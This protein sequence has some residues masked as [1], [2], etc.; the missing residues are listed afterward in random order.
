MLNFVF[1][2]SEIIYDGAKM[3]LK[4][5]TVEKWIISDKSQTGRIF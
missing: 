4:I 3:I 2:K 1:S 5:K